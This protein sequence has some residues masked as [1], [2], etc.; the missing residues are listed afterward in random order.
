MKVW[1]LSET[2]LNS[3]FVSPKW[4]YPCSFR[5]DAP[6]LLSEFCCQH[7][8]VWLNEFQKHGVAV[9]MERS[10]A[11]GDSCCALRVARGVSGAEGNKA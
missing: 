10:M 5:E 1:I 7:G 6:A 8:T 3:T 4:P 9:G 2:I 11:W